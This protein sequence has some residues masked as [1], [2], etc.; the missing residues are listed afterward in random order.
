MAD[1]TIALGDL[2]IGAVIG[3]LGAVQ[4]VALPGMIAIG[5]G[6]DVVAAA[7][8]A[9]EPKWFPESEALSVVD[10]LATALGTTLGWVLVRTL[11]PGA[12]PTGHEPIIAASLAAA[13]LP[14]R[15]PGRLRRASYRFMR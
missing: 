9:I 5:V 10:V 11:L 8:Y 4:G 3:A 15:F 13:P 6:F 7:T 14:A 1:G 2:A 12:N